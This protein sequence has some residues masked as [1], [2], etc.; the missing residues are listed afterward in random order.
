MNWGLTAIGAAVLSVVGTLVWTGRASAASSSGSNDGGVGGGGVGGGG[1]GGGGGGVNIDLG[2]LPTA[3]D[4]IGD[5]VANW[6]DTP[7]DLR[8]L[9]M[10]MEE[11]SKIVG[12]ARVF[13]V[14]AFRESQFVTSAQNGDAANE[15]AE[16]DSSRR[17]YDNGKANNPPLRFGE[18]AAGFGSGGLFGALAPYFLWTGVPE[19]GKKAPL[20]R[21][22]PELCFQPRAAA[23]AA[24]VYMQRLLAHYQIDDVADIK[25]G[26]ASPSL[27]KTGRGSKSY[28]DVRAM[29]LADAMTLGI[30]V[31]VIPKLSA[32]AWPGVPAVFQALVGSLPPEYA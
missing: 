28:K 22:P 15:Q 24:C 20:L 21:A 31:T 8:P 3:A 19:V 9:M 25:A 2:P 13:A 23:F 6:G 18:E 5:L 12:S 16:R 4:V 7:P 26:W 29:F 30:D 11:V 32:A 1:A 10:R 27:L 17:G 14:I